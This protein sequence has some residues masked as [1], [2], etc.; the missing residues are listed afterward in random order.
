MHGTGHLHNA[1]ILYFRTILPAFPFPL[2]ATTPISPLPFSLPSFPFIL[3]LPFHKEVS[4]KL[5][6]RRQNALSVIKTHEP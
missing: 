3:P 5:S 1:N 2:L 6:Y 4:K